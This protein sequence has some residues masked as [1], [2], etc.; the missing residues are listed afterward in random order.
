MEPIGDEREQLTLSISVGVT[1]VTSIAIVTNV[2]Y[3][4]LLH[5]VY[6]ACISVRLSSG[7]TNMRIHAC[8]PTVTK[9]PN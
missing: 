6:D 9:C 2:L 1:E 7:V 8:N 5:N 4:C 3:A